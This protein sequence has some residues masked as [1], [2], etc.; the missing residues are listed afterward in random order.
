MWSVGTPTPQHVLMC[1]RLNQ[2][3]K[4]GRYNVDESAVDS[5]AWYH[6]VCTRVPEA[7]GYGEGSISTKVRK[8]QVFAVVLPGEPE[9]VCQDEG[10]IHTMVGEVQCGVVPCS[11][12]QSA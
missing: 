7:V 5:N 8:G 4:R 11:V 12:H 3:K 2:P 6:V 1:F 10:S 9:T